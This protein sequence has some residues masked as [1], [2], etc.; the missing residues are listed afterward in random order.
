LASWIRTGNFETPDPPVQG[1]RDIR[2]ISEQSRNS[3]NFV[4]RNTF[5][6]TRLLNTINIHKKT[7]I[8]WNF[9]KVNDKF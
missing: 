5:A 8:S 7:K 4:L 1:A 3:A 6:G 2:G 9:K